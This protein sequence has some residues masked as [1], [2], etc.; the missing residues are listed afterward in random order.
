MQKMLV[1]KAAYQILTAEHAK[2]CYKTA[3]FNCQ[4]YKNNK[5]V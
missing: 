2:L 4:K 3:N 5:F 1:L